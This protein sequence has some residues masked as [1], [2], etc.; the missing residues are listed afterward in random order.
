MPDIIVPYLDCE[1]MATAVCGLHDNPDLR[2]RLGDRA[3]KKVM[4]RH[5]I[6]VG[7]QHIY[8]IIKQQIGHSPGNPQ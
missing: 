4:E 6:S 2:R 3:R 5:D 1:E 7:G 8:N